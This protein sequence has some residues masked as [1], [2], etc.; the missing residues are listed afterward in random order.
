MRNVYDVTVSILG[1][2]FRGRFKRN[3]ECLVSVIDRETV[4]KCYKRA[5]YYLNYGTIPETIE[6]GIACGSGYFRIQFLAT[7][8]RSGEE[9]V[10]NFTLL[11]TRDSCSVIADLRFALLGEF[12][13]EETV[14]SLFNF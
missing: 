5:L 10:Y 13:N 4:E 3:S 12:V 14:F 6:L 11:A 9:H 8:S 1:I 2:E 7:L